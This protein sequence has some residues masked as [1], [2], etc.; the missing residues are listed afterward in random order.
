MIPCNTCPHPQHDR[1]VKINFEG[2]HPCHEDGNLPC[3][4]HIIHQKL[5]ESGEVI[6]NGDIVNLFF[7]GQQV[8]TNEQWQSLR[9]NK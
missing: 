6:P 8:T 9:R 1:N 3:R 2:I 7:N 4:G 5:I